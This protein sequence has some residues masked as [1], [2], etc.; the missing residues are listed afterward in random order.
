M[1]TTP[2]DAPDDVITPSAA[3]SS[4]SAYVMFERCTSGL[5]ATGTARRTSCSSG[6]CRRMWASA[7]AR[8][9]PVWDSA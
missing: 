8:A 9:S 6:Y 1:A 5:P 2:H 4:S 3:R 7:T